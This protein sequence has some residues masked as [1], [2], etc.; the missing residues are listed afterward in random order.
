MAN[1]EALAIDAENQRAQLEHAIAVLVGRPPA[2]FA[3]TPVARLPLAPAI[4]DL[5]T[6][7]VLEHRPDIAAAERRMAAANAQIGVAE[8]A[9]F[10]LL[11]LAG[12]FGYRSS[13]LRDLINAPGRFWSIIP[14]LA[15]PL[16]DGG[17]RSAAVSQAAAGYDQSVASYR[18]TV[19]TAFQEVEDNL[20]TACWRKK[21][22]SRPERWPLPG[23]RARSPRTSTRPASAAR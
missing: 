18:Q 23:V 20:S 22:K 13:A 5:I 9:Y 12:N 4:P 2:L 15:V 21:A 6:S 11:D 19:L 8:A 10:P 7:V 14:A 1:T 16:F 3:I 17:A